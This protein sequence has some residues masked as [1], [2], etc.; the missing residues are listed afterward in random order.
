MVEFVFVQFLEF[1]GILPI[2]S[3]KLVLGNPKFI[4]GYF[5]WSIDIAHCFIFM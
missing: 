2:H 3:P 4:E 1:N 5:M